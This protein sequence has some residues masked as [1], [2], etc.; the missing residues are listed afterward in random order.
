MGASAREAF[1][2]TGV[3]VK[4]TGILGIREMHEGFR[5][6]TADLS[7]SCLMTLEDHN[8]TTLNKCDHELLE[9]RWV[10]FEELKG[11]QLHI[12]AHDTMHNIL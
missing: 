6:G 2:E 7:I 9:C 3:K 8:D 10:N 1:E 12:T 5:F 11:V 4:F